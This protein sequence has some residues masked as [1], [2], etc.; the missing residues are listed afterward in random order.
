MHESFGLDHAWYFSAQ[1]LAW[2][3]ALKIRK[4]ELE[5]LSDTNMLLVIESDIRGGMYD[6]HY[7]YIK[8]KY[9]AKSKLLFTDTDS[10]AYEI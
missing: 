1:G 6:F 7:N 4:V 9:G 8:T 10:L 2:D 5:L 3:A